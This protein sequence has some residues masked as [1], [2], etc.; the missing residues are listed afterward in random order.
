MR[1]REKL[2]IDEI[3]KDL[4]PLQDL[5]VQKGQWGKFPLLGSERNCAKVVREI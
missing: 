2:T 1:L 5:Y 3:L 4:L